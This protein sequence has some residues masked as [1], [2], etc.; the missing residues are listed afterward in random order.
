MKQTLKKLLA[1]DKLY[2]SIK[3]SFFYQSYKK[4][5]AKIAN[6]LYDNPSKDFFVIWITGTNGKTTTVNILH[7]ILNDNVAPTVAISTATI[8]IWNEVL[9][10]EKKMT[11]LDNFDLQS[12]LATA[13]QKGCKIAILEVSS[14]GLEQA[15]FEGIKFD[16]AVLT[17][18]TQDHLDYHGNMESYA[19]AK[20]KLFKY[21]LQNW[22]ENKYAA[23][24][25]DD[26]YGKKRFEE[27]AFD[28][29]VSF[30]LQNSSVL[31]AT[32]I[33]E[34][35]EGTYFEF[36][37]LGQKYN[38]T[39]QLIGSYNIAN[40]LAA[41]SVSTEI[42]LEI[43]LAL[44]SVENFPGVSWRMEPVYTAQGVKYYVDFAHTPDGIEKTLAFAQK[45]KGNGKLIAVC[46]APG[47]RDKEK[48]PIMGDIALQYADTA[49]FTDDDP[50]TENRLKIL[51]NMS[52][53]VQ[54]TFLADEKEAFIIPERWYAIKFATEIARPGDVVVLA[55]KG[56]ET[57]QLTN[58]G[59]R[60]WNDKKNL[61]TLLQSQGKTLLNSKEIKKQYLI[62]LKNRTNPN[63]ITPEQYLHEGDDTQK[64][65]HQTPIPQQT[66]GMFK[67]I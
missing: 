48:R 5:R 47:N 11:S 6:S 20:K 4:Y 37:Y 3:T 46:W 51:D 13:K 58:F 50:D 55:G 40:I 34:G 62:E 9:A 14:H 57:V 59:K 38:G 15:R 45:N 28:K 10:N 33:Q 64:I 39:T 61:I 25:V 1:Y 42:G 43:P 22:K 66:S 30:S 19:E 60:E 24:C 31:K 54:S 18:I 23:I 44:K 65:S 8:K 67:S 21:V 17:N 36:S 27:M 12:L 63:H 16:F 53:N 26:R 41:L 56:H 32:H 49:I 2:D 29:K 35:L 7:K 52:K